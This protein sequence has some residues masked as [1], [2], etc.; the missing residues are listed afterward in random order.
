MD[1]EEAYL[2]LGLDC[3]A[4]D[5]E[6]KASWRK[7]VARWHPDR[8]P[9]ADAVQ[10]MQAIN[11]AYQHI[12]LVRE[13]KLAEVAAPPPPA[14]APS[15]SQAHTQRPLCVRKVRLSLEDACLGCIRTVRGQFSQTCPSCTGTGQ[16]VLASACP[17]CR[18]KGAV[19]KAA[20]FG[21]L[22][23]E[24]PCPNCGGDGRQRSLCD[25][26]EATGAQTLHYRR[27]VR[28]PGGT[29]EGHVLSVPAA[30][31]G[32]LQVDLEL[33]IQVEH[34]PLFTLDDQGV[35]RCEMPVNGYAWMTERWVDVP[36]PDGL[37]HMRLARDARVYR[38]AGKGFPAVPNGPRGDFIVRVTPVFPPL[39]DP[40]QTDLLD[41]LIAQS[42]QV[43]QAD[44][45]QPLGQWARRM[46]SWQ[47]N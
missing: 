19:R 38:L 37:Q 3:R 22:W 26:C 33:H 5:A 27:K 21:W 32:D 20:L 7:L 30:R 28:F 8:N 44:V 9:A 24:E 12:R 4:S 39:D 13:G 46:A 17:T 47:L 11:K 1:T 31:H 43:A 2:A 18:G 23:T 41:R 10:R 14:S 29:R 35:L 40:Q 36:T 15:A 16:R 6:L 25:G 42:T 34:H 45:D